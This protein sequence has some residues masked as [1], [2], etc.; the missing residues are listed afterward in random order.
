MYSY[1]CIYVYKN[2]YVHTYP[3]QPAAQVLHATLLH[4]H[5]MTTN[6]VPVLIF[7]C[8]QHPTKIKS[9]CQCN[10]EIIF[11]IEMRRKKLHSASK[12]DARM[13]NCVAVFVS[14]CVTESWVSKDGSA[15]VPRCC[16]VM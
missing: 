7:F 2:T 14:D 8:V 9:K 4:S 10:K 13:T 11:K 12:C 5:A 3:Q 1:T 6:L 16:Q 15:I